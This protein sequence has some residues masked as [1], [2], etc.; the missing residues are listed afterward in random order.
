MILF[1][2]VDDSFVHAFGAGFGVQF[3]IGE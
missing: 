3:R 1:P 2:A